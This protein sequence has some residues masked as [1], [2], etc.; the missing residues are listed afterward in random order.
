M[1]YIPANHKTQIYK[2][3]SNKISTYSQSTGRMENRLLSLLAWEINFINTKVTLE[4]GSATVVY[5]GENLRKEVIHNEFEDQSYEI[6]EYGRNLSILSELY[7]FISFHFFDF[8][9]D[10]LKQAA[11]FLLQEKPNLKIYNRN[12]TQDDINMLTN[13]RNLYVISNFTSDEL[14]D[15][16]VYDYKIYLLKNDLE[17][18]EINRSTFSNNA[19]E[20][21]ALF[22][23]IKER[24]NISD[25]EKSKEI[26]DILKPKAAMVK[27]RPNHLGEDEDFTYYDGILLLPIFSS[28]KSME[29]RLIVTDYDKLIK[30]NFKNLR[31]N[32]TFW[33]NKTRELP[34]LNP[35]SNTA[36]PLPYQ[37]GNQMEMC[38]LFSILRDYFATMKVVANSED[39]YS[40]YSDL[41]ADSAENEEYCYG[42]I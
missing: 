38:V 12:I 25:M 35:F 24:K 5:I 16:K 18:N 2:P 28:H 30:W 10:S 13:D 40:L 26:V 23:G 37:L 15:E 33:N 8:I 4:N 34:A 42:K 29:C 36:A 9:N 22:F 39:V 7:P 20:E 27:F 17:D 3:S 32:I 19:K 21:K 6:F 11:T 31:E 14:R 1:N 41:M